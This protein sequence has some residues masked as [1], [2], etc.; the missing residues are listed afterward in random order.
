MWGVFLMTRLPASSSSRGGWQAT[1]PYHRKSQVTACRKACMA[2]TT[3]QEASHRVL[4]Q[5]KFWCLQAPTFDRQRAHIL[6]DPRL[7]IILPPDE[8]LDAQVP[9]V[10]PQGVLTDE[11]LDAGGSAAPALTDASGSAGGVAAARGRSRRGPGAVANRTGG[12]QQA[13]SSSTGPAAALPSGRGRGRQRQAEVPQKAKRRK[14]LSSESSGSKLVSSESSGSSSS[15]S[16]SS[17]S[18]STSD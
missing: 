7:E 12:H 2:A 3:S 10:V 16:S 5:L 1:C 13:A 4:R 11:Q 6:L 17:D 15:S 9:T 18:S 14:L 8:V